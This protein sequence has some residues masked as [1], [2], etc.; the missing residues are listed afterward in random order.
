[1]QPLLQQRDPPSRL[2]PVALELGLARPSGPDA[3]AELARAAAA[4]EPFEVLPHAAH[5]GQVV[6]QLRQLDLEL[7]LTASGVLGEDVEDQLGP[8]D[9]ACG[10]RI[11]DPPLL[12]WAEL[13]VDDDDLCPGLAI[14][15]LQLLE[16][17]LPEVGA[18]I[19]PLAM[20]DSLADRL[21]RG[22]AAE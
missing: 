19:R 1:L 22:G 16:L 18:R 9:D 7:A 21:D 13:V 4:G 8:V 12:R 3:A 10:Q 15:L 11:L 5:P 20:L 6:F 2:S 14:R 17:P